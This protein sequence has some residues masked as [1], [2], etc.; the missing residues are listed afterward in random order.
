MNYFRNILAISIAYLLVAFSPSANAQ[1]YIAASWCTHTGVERLNADFNADGRNDALCVDRTSGHKWIAIH[2]GRGLIQRWEDAISRWCTHAGATLYV[3]DVN[4]DRHADL[5]CRDPGRIWVDTYE[6][7]W[8]GEPQYFQGHNYTVDTSWC[9][10]GSYFMGFADQN[11]D[12]RVDMTC[13]TDTGFYWVSHADASGRY[14]GTSVGAEGFRPDFFI[15][16]VTIA[17]ET[18][19]GRTFRVHVVNNSPIAGVVTELACRGSAGPS[20]INRGVTPLLVYGFSSA[21]FEVNYSLAFLSQCSVSGIDE[22]GN[23]ELYISNNTRFR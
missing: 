18:L 8:L 3:G 2:D 6:N 9:H 17:R 15:A 23:P 16:S 14:A 10:S 19:T 4:G 5:I 21:Y 1:A 11:R 22:F 20:S 12:G 13:R 7:N